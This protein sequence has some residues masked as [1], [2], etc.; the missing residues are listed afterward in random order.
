MGC[1]V[2][3]HS[4]GGEERAS[5]CSDVAI[6]PAVKSSWMV[7]HSNSA[8]TMVDDDGGDDDAVARDISN[9]GYRVETRASTANL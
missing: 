2:E 3:E 6:A 8:T 5:P 1:G 4:E 9:T 7:E